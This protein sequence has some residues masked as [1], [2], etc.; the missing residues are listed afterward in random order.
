MRLRTLLLTGALAL[1]LAGPATAATAT[2]LTVDGGWQ[3]F[4]FSNAVGAAWSD[5]FSFVL[6]VPTF[7]KIVDGGKAGDQFS[8]NLNGASFN[9]LTSNVATSQTSL[10]ADWDAAYAN[11]LWS[12]LTLLLTPGTYTLTGTVA[13]V[14]LGSG[15]GA[16]ELE[17]A[18]TVPVPAPIAAAGLPGVLAL[19]AA[20]LFRRRRA[21]A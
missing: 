5:A 20:L 13:K 9:L 1:G 11:P 3:S 15:L 12:S 19:G 6:T 17:T 4:S 2:P 8:I 7:L 14:P 18:S 21:V 16:V 10:G